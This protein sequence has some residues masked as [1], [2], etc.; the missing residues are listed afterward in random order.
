MLSDWLAL[1][2]LLSAL[3]VSA[4]WLH[5][6]T[7]GVPKTPHGVINLGA[8]TPRS[9][10]GKPDLSG[11][12]EAENTF[13]CN[14]NLT[15]CN[16]FKIGAQFLNFGAT[17]KD[18]L[19]YQ[20]WAAEIS[21]TRAAGNRKDDPATRCLPPGVP[22]NDALPTFKKIVQTPGLLI[23]LDEF[24][25]TF[26]QIFTDGRP[27]PVDPNPT[28]D[29]YSIGHWDGDT[30]VVE[31][32]GVTNNQW[33]DTRGDPIT[34]DAKVTERFHRLNFGNMDVDVTVNDPKAY[35]APWT[36]KIHQYIVLNTEMIDYFCLENERDV[37]HL[38]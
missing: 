5:Y 12:W 16:D 1:A 20:P 9:A 33:L 7:A 21:K 27:L 35:T 17:L 25:A 18:G 38:K 22:R 8:P 36:V 26:R 31:T 37:R 29:G 3:P 13:A 14:P 30:M 32:I 11:M 10:E 15:A 24:N 23:I 28:F 34:E 19:P 2:A 4:Q 6:P